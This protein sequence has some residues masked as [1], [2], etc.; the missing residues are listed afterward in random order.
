MISTIDLEN[1]YTSGVYSKRSVVFEHGCGALL[2]DAEGREYIDCTAG[3]GV[4]NI[5]HGRPEIA[6]TLVAQAQRLI[7]CPEIF[8]NDV[9]ARLLERLAHLVPQ[10]LTHIF[11]CNSG[12]EAIEGAL[13][14]ARIATG[15]TGIV[16]TL[17][18]FHGRTMGALSTTWEPHYREPFVPLV[19]DVSHIRYNDLAAA[20]AAVSE[21]TA[22]VIIELVQ[23]EG[24]VHV[25]N[26]QYVH[27]LAALCR[28]RGAL[29]IVDEVQTGFGR[30][31]RL[32]ACNH[33]DLRPDILC[34]AK[35]LAGGFPMGAVCLGQ[36]VM[37]SGRIT[38]G[39]HGSTFGGNPLACAA[40]L[41]TL[42][43]LE[44]EA[45]PE[46]AAALGNRALERLLTFRIPLIREVRGRGLLL[47]IEL[48]KRAQPFL[49]A[50]FER[51]VL[52]L[53]AG[54][55]VIR[56]L[57]PLVI[58]EEQLERTLDVV[59]EV[60]GGQASRVM[61]R[62]TA[63]MI[64]KDANS[65]E[66]FDSHS[67]NGA[68]VSAQMNER[69][70]VQM[71]ERVTARVAAEVN[72][73]VTAVVN[74][75]VNAESERVT[76]RVTPTIYGRAGEANLGC[77][78][79]SGG[80]RGCEEVSLLHNMLM[81]PSYSG[82]EHALAQHL[83]EQAQQMGLY[84]C[85]DGAG[86]FIASTHPHVIDVGIERGISGVGICEAG[87]EGDGSDHVGF[88]SIQ[89]GDGGDPRV[90]SPRPHH[91]RPYGDGGDGGDVGE[92]GEDGGDSGDG[93]DVGNGGK[94]GDVGEGGKDGMGRPIV[95]LGHMDTVRGIIPVRLQDGVLYGRGAVDAKG[96]LA[97]FLCAAA[98]LAQGGHVGALEHPIVV[99]GA[100]EEE[101]ATSRGARAV[102]ER[103]R[104]CACI[105]GEPSG[106]Q[107]VTI[108]YKGR[109]LV[110]YCVT[111]SIQ[112]S[113]G[114]QQ[115]SNE[116]AVA[117]WHRVQQYAADWNQQHAAD[118]TFAALMPSLRSMQSDQDGLEEQA[119]LFIGF[120]LPP[121]Y[122]TTGLRTQLERWAVEDEAQLNFSGEEMAFQTTRTT[123]L[124]RAFI[125]SIRATGRRPSFKH[126]TGTSDM[127]V[128]GP[129]WGQNILAYGPGDA[130]LDHTPQEH[131]DISEYIHA[132]DVLEL[133]LSELA[134]RGRVTL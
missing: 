35:S 50:L 32:F 94:S 9:R 106:S 105:I 87:R 117:F 61:A 3:Y 125:A 119:R 29:L 72:E 123:P 84:A 69:V 129:V 17:R 109:L 85:I 34:L 37:E 38:R 67:S 57:P 77:G 89:D 16:A 18:G 22:A 52:A 128:V 15:R 79:D 132:I 71:D 33:Y 66:V 88:L 114:P 5:G 78:D 49:E 74:E 134:L 62:E 80:L 98:R 70:S 25:A 12:T 28:E 113:A 91:T 93:G 14:F 4:A 56:L 127:N 44:R 20:E 104:P 63:N 54:P 115:N 40:A 101:A 53:Q 55:N 41:T 131:I 11:L 102:L 31:G 122:D 1:T 121:G 75:K 90:P 23:G 96:P 95:L 45:L 81:I 47:G 97:A 8:Y 30:T 43:I 58:T 82:E 24:G 39:I 116:V 83:L 65:N 124:A 110:E 108:G 112:H 92:G 42:D 10:D 59:E 26:E 36:H 13:K 76:A 2:I 73:R 111:R 133:V 126:K 21:Q 68:R 99:I 100:V 86:N 64:R 46:R 48:S 19:P 60:L 103:Y 130:R 27:G 51:G 7:T 118:S 107:A 6:A 120:R